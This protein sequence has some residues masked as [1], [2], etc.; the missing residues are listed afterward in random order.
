MSGANRLC[1]QR[2][3]LKDADSP[4][5]DVDPRRGGIWA[6]HRA[7][8]VVVVMVYDLLHLAPVDIAANHAND[9][10]HDKQLP[11]TGNQAERYTSAEATAGPHD[12]VLRVTAYRLLAG[13]NRIRWTRLHSHG[14]QFSVQIQSIGGLLLLPP[15]GPGCSLRVARR[16]LRVVRGRA[17][18]CTWR[19]H[20]TRR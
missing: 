6:S 8:L 2:A 15:R 19:R 13:F 3:R 14:T 4:E 20:R 5:P 9:K 11:R 1:G 7:C 16:V 18:A 12:C 17:P 10:A